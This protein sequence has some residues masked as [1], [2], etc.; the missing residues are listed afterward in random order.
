MNISEY[1]NLRENKKHIELFFPYN[2]YLCSIP[3]DF[4]DVPMHWHEE[5]ELIVIKK[6]RGCVTLDLEKRVVE[7]GQ[8]VIVL[9]GQLHAISQYQQESM[10]YEN[11]IF[12]PEMLYAKESDICTIEFFEP[13]REGRILY[14]GWIDGTKNYHLEMTE[15][16]KK[17]DTL[18]DERPRGYQIGLKGW[19]NQ[20]FFILFSNEE[21]RKADI[22]KEKS[23]IKMKQILKKIETD[24]QKPLDI[25]EMAEFAGYSESHFMK[26]FKNHMGTPFIQYLNEYRLTMAARRLLGSEEDVLTVALDT[27][28]ANVSY[29]NRL[30]KQRFRMT[31]LEYRKIRSRS[32]LST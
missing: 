23:R 13:Y 18:C 20:F 15:C 17:M 21:P 28:F 30:F 11:I 2:T 7:A 3:L 24:Y 10:E 22:G 12:R 31:P 27:G 19:L 8:I 26:F 4:F 32:S 16:V 25:E 5:L 14:S 1:E 9:P 6:G 29:F